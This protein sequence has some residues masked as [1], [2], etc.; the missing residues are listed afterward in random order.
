MRA[1]LQSY[2]NGYGQ[3]AVDNFG[4]FEE[5]VVQI[6]FILNTLFIIIVMLNLLISIVGATFGRVLDNKDRMMY[7]DM[8]DLIV[9][10]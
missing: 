9:E 8:V 6:F 7:Q 2:M 10:N 1:L 4:I 5:L 3:F